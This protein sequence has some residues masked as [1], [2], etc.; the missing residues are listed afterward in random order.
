MKPLNAKP[1]R[2]FFAPDLFHPGDNL[3]AEF[4]YVGTAGTIVAG[5]LDRTDTMDGA[6]VGGLPESEMG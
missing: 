1:A 4:V 6:G 5:R 2:F 3:M